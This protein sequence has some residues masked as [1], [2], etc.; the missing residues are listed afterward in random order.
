MQQT[1]EDPQYA[2]RV[3]TGKNSWV[4]FETPTGL[5]SNG[6]TKS[7]QL[8]P[9]E[10]YLLKPSR[11]PLIGRYRSSYSKRDIPALLPAS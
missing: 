4:A 5:F 6:A 1:W 11:G 3:W 9:G 10:Q 8:S 7:S 2:A